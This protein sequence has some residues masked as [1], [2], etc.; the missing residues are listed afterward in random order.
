M[1]E[2]AESQI[3][4][5]VKVLKEDYV[6]VAKQHLSKTQTLLCFRG[7]D[8]KIAEDAKRLLFNRKLS[9]FQLGYYFFVF[10]DQFLEYFF[11]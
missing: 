7:S 9:I 11:F 4:Q 6:G 3:L 10:M 1:D 5:V 2:V 8:L